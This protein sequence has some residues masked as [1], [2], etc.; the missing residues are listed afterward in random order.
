MRKNQCCGNC[1]W[2][3][4]RRDESLDDMSPLDRQV[5]EDMVGPGT[6][7]QWHSDS[8]ICTNR[9]SRDCGLAV[10]ER[11][12]CQL[13]ERPRHLRVVRPGENDDELSF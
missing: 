9:K 3:G 12:N 10:L 2:S 11:S 1:R 13:C 7:D 8:L 5:Y 6:V 4:T